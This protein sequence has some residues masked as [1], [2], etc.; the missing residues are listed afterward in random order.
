LLILNKKEKIMLK[1]LMLT[2][3]AILVAAGSV[4]AAAPDR[5]NRLE[6]GV[7]GGGAFNESGLDDAGYAQANVAYGVH[8]N[9]A[10]G[11]EGGWQ[12]GDTDALNE[13]SIGIGLVLADIIVRCPDVH[14]AL[15]PY[16]V[17]GLGGAGA[18][19]TNENGTGALQGDDSDDTAFAWKLGGGLDWFINPNWVIN[20][21]VGWV[22]LDVE[23]QTASTQPSEMLTVTGGLK[24]VF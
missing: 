22:D 20:F 9:I 19:A 21:E 5:V 7:S 8:R 4:W 11:V 16:F 12:E 13:E 1:R 23:L 10:I 6:I 24:F 14:D 3:T 15:V 2:L 18:Y 17:V